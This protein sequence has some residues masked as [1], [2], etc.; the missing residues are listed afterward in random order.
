[1]NGKNNN[2]GKRRKRKIV[3]YPKIN[4]NKRKKLKSFEVCR[5][6][7]AETKSVLSFYIRNLQLL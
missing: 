7:E 3:L 2:K 1:M 4:V 6:I 5:N